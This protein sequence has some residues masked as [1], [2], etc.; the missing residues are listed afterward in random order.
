LTRS[1][2]GGLFE[3]VVRFR[4]LV[5]LLVLLCD[6]ALAMG[7]SGEDLPPPPFEIY[8]HGSSTIGGR[9][10]SVYHVTTLSDGSGRGTLR[11][12][13]SRPNRYVVFDVSGT[14]HLP[15]NLLLDQP[16][17]TVDGSTAPN[18]GVQ[19]P[20]SGSWQRTRSSCGICGSGRARI[21]PESCSHAIASP[22]TTER[23]SCS[24][25]SP[26]AGG[27]TRT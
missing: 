20:A 24:T 21:R 25:T 2:L 22:S 10:G 1:K 3:G 8:G 19:V 12:A 18:G 11:D 6:P 17:I 15:G 14:I 5:V 9:S 7:K 23:T 4:S 16:N 13:V 26:A 27:R